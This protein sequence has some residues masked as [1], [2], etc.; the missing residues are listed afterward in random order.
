VSSVRPFFEQHY[1]R[2]VGDEY[3]RLAGSIHRQIAD[4][5]QAEYGSSCFDYLVF[6]ASHIFIKSGPDRISEWQWFHFCLKSPPDYPSEYKLSEPLSSKLAT[7]K[8]SLL[9]GIEEF[10]RQTSIAEQHL[11][12]ADLQLMALGQLKPEDVFTSIELI[13]HLNIFVLAWEQHC[14]SLSHGD[15]KELFEWS[16]YVAPD[17][18]IDQSDIAFPG[19][20]RFELR[21]AFERMGL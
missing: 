21:P 11:S 4:S 9:A 17:I 12:T 6:W 8:G 20:W 19:N 2:L 5:F 3:F 14:G 18:G 10:D 7:V 1:N 15:L 16:H 13:A